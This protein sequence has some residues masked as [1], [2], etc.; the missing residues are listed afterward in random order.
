MR[1]YRHHRVK[2]MSIKAGRFIKELFEA[3]VAEPLQLPP[4]F[5]KHV[6]EVGLY[7]GVCDYIA[8]MTDRYA[9]DEY[10]KL[11]YPYELT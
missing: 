9:Q 1:M 4:E 2:R 11:F 10:K 8:G 6:E 3:Y 7:R 5:Q